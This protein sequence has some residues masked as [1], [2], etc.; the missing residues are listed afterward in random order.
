MKNYIEEIKKIGSQC[1]SDQRYGIF[2]LGV[3][4]QKTNILGF[5]WNYKYFNKEDGKIK[6]ISCVDLTGL[7]KKVEDKGLE[8][9]ITDVEQAQKIY[10][11]NREA[12]SVRQDIQKK[13]T[14]TRYRQTKSGVR[15][16]G[17][18]TN[19]NKE[20]WTYQNYTKDSQQKKIHISS[21]TLLGLKK[22]VLDR[23]GKWEIINH[24]RYE[25][26][27]KEVLL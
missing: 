3:C 8:W 18:T 24:E 9:I 12:Q 4:A 26:A 13:R 20:Y 2:R 23:G 21:R 11:I 14:H 7:R 27:L 6:T 19:H 10:D 15:Y 16:V 25:E 17:K 22:K 1:K 5:M